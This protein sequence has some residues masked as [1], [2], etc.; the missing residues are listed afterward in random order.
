MLGLLIR[1]IRRRREF[2]D[3][4]KY[5]VTYVNRFTILGQQSG[6]GY[7]IANP[8]FDFIGPIITQGDAENLLLAALEEIRG[9]PFSDDEKEKARAHWSKK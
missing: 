3:P 6:P 5:K 8:S 7:Y 1:S 4:K 9:K 2:R